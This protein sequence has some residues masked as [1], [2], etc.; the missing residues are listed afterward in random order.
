MKTPFGDNHDSD[1]VS[2]VH[3]PT[4][5]SKSKVLRGDS[6]RCGDSHPENAQ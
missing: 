3:F 4:T 6:T 5:S 2:D 1:D